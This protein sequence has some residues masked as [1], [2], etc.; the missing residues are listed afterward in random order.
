MRPQGFQWGEVGSRDAILEMGG[1]GEWDGEC[2]E[3]GRGGGWRL[4]CEKR[5]NNNDKKLKI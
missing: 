2:S 5:L 4:D 1:V 3:D